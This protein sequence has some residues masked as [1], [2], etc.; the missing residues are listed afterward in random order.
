M[1]LDGTIFSWGRNNYGQLGRFSNPRV[2]IGLQRIDSTRKIIQLEVGSE[3]NV[4]LAGNCKA[5][6]TSAYKDH[7]YN[8]SKL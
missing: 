1:I 3:H 4:A 2:S 6:N 8:K 7:L 5:I